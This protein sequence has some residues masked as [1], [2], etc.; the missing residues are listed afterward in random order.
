FIAEPVQGAGGVIVPPRTY[1][2]K[3]QAVLAKYDSLLIADEVITGFARTG[4]MFGTETYGMKPD[5][6]SV[7]KQ[8]SSAY[9]PISAVLINRKVYD[10]IR[11]NSGKIGTFGHGYTYTGHPVSAAVAL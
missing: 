11:D 1:F 2:E 5:I 7:A 4:N 9:L 10:V 3:S 6:I 8:L